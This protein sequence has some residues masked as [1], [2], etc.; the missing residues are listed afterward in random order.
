VHGHEEVTNARTHGLGRLQKGA[1][2]YSRTVLIG[3]DHR[4]T[5]ANS[6]GTLQKEAGLEPWSRPAWQRLEQ[7]A[8]S[9]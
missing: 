8:Q 3:G 6:L 9:S 5:M 1:V 4:T 7:Q 2:S